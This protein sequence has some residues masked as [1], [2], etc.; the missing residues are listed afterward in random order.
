MPAPKIGRAQKPNSEIGRAQRPNKK[1]PI[2]KKQAATA[3]LL[4]IDQRGPHC[5]QDFA[6]EN[7]EPAAE[8]LEEN[9]TSKI[10]SKQQHHFAS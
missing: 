7:T 5:T 4:F 3:P 2:S 9:P 6:Q 1:H 10:E 8:N